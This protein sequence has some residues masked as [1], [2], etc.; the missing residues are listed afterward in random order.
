MNANPSRVVRQV[1][2]FDSALRATR[3][4]VSSG[5]YLGTRC[6]LCIVYQVRAF[7]AQKQCRYAPTFVGE[8]RHRLPRKGASLRSFGPLDGSPSA[9]A[10]RQSGRRT[11]ALRAVLLQL[12]G[13]MMTTVVIDMRDTAI[14]N[15]HPI[16]REPVSRLVAAAA[17]MPFR[18]GMV[19]GVFQLFEGYRSP[20][21]Q[22][23]LLTRT[24]STKAGPWESA[25]QYG[26]AVD[27]AMAVV[28]ENAGIQWY[29]PHNAPWSSLKRLAMIEELDIPIAWD[30]GH[31][32]HPEFALV[33][34]AFS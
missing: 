30:K 25:H 15:L 21:R 1:P 7:Q 8:G 4:T 33:R 27:F 12:M 11:G 29:W 6:H 13:E 5:R 20:E 22:Q 31:V 34:S 19:E 32:Q 23:H 18:V 16:M 28:K 26:L 10:G 3:R 14:I 9:L 2:P 17:A 24:K